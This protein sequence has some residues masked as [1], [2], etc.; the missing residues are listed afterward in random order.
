M[1]TYLLCSTDNNVY[2]NIA[3]EKILTE[4]LPGGSIA[5]MLWRNDKCVVIGK[6]QCAQN[7]CDLTA[8]KNGNIK[9]ARRFSGGGAVYHDKNNLNFTFAASP[10]IYNVSRQLTVVENAVN[11]L[12]FNC[13]RS[14]RNDITIDGRKFSGN[15]FLH[16]SNASFHHG[17]I[18]IDTDTST[19][20]KCLTVNKAKL[21]SNGVQSVV[22]RIVNLKELNTSVTCESV[23]DALVKSFYSEYGKAETLL[24]DRFASRAAELSK[25]LSLEKWLLGE[26]IKLNSRASARF[27][28]GSVDVEFE[29]RGSKLESLQIFSDALDVEGIDTAR[30]DLIGIDLNDD[31]ERPQIQSE[32]VNLIK[33]NGGLM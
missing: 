31:K 26:N 23:A 22:S 21:Q 2:F 15:A 20:S 28:W 8:M 14:G 12:G 5:L 10:G 32:I 7:E 33:T 19:L 6:N 13:T 16:H 25:T 4:T 24:Q 27:S 29:V 1:K 11:S 9:L 30:K 3:L 18:L 17:T